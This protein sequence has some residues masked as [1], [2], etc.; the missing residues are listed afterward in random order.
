MKKLSSVFLGIFL[1][2]TGFTGVSFAGVGVDLSLSEAETPL[3]K[4]VDVMVEILRLYAEEALDPPEDMVSC[5]QEMYAMRRLGKCR[6]K[7]SHYVPP[8]E[9]PEFLAEYKGEFGGV[10]L[11]ITQKDDRV[12]VV[13]PIEDT[14]GERAGFKPEDVILEVDGKEVDNALQAIRLIRGPKGSNVEIK[15]LRKAFTEPKTAVLVREKII[16]RFV[17]SR[18]LSVVGQK[19]KVIKVSSFAEK[20]SGQFR[21]AFREAK[22][23]G[24][25]L[26]ALDFR[27][28]PGGL[29]NQ[30][31]KTL[32]LFMR[33]DDVIVTYRTRNTSEPYDLAYLREKF[34]VTTFGEFRDDFKVVILINKGS[35]SA[36]EIFSG[37][38]K[39]WG[40]KV[41]GETA[42]EVKKDKGV[43]FGKG[44]GQTCIPL[45][46]GALFCLTTFEFLV[47]NNRVPIRDKGVVPDV[48]VQESEKK[49]DDKALDK[50]IEILLE[51]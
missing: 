23:N 9:V 1:V 16:V 45:L 50:A 28:N 17:K 14:P 37:T 40:Y 4:Q 42:G 44:V 47:G 11:E 21:D 46:D 38:M 7:F 10:G 26:V 34:D 20:T 49:D 35:A 43:T 33:R 39:D 36:S 31:L 18:E 24:I 25:K 19:I 3:A 27:N 29:L 30:A 13:A 15:F 12:V 6:D 48:T 8:S 2:L 5:L 22:R 51:K 41:V 32:A